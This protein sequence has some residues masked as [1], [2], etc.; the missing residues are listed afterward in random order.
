[1]ELAQC[2]CC[3]VQLQ[4]D[5]FAIIAGTQLKVCP[6]LFAD[7]ES[8]L[9][10]M[11]SVGQAGR[12]VLQVIRGEAGQIRHRQFQALMQCNQIEQRV[13]VT[14]KLP[15][16]GHPALFG[17]QYVPGVEVVVTGLQELL[18]RLLCGVGG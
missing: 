11:Q 6:A 4:P 15:V 17:D 12:V 2:F 1:M 14:G 9:G 3:G 8:A 16:Q 7:P 13:V 18:C 10:G 5:L